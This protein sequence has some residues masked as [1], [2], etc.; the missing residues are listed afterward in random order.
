MQR[1]IGP[2]AISDLDV[3]REGDSI[4]LRFRATGKEKGIHSIRIVRNK[5]QIGA[6][7]CPGCPRAY[8][9]VAE[10][11]SKDLQAMEKGNSFSYRDDS[12]ERGYRYLYKIVVSDRDETRS[13]EF[14]TDEITFE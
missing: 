10:L 4:R 8:E 12:V 1:L 14:L 13:R 11:T 9:Q 3:S 2:A 6:G 7:E 5:L